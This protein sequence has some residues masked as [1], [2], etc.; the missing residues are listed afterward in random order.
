MRSRKFALADFCLRHTIST[1]YASFVLLCFILTTFVVRWETLVTRIQIYNSQDPERPVE[2]FEQQRQYLRNQTKTSYK[3]S[4]ISSNKVTEK[5]KYADV[6]LKFKEKKNIT[7]KYQAKYYQAAP[8]ER[9][10]AKIENK[11][12]PENYIL[13]KKRFV[14]SVSCAKIVRGSKRE[15]T[16]SADLGNDYLSVLSPSYYIRKTE[17]CDDFINTREYITDSLSKEE[18]EFPLAY[19]ILVY[20][21]VY[22]FERL[23]RSIYRPQNFYCIHADMKMSD[24]D[25]DAVRYIISCFD[26]VFFSSKAYN[27]AWGTFSV[28]A[29]D[30]TCMTNL[31]KYKWKYFINL[32]GQEF[33][34]KTNREIVKILKSFNG[35]ND[36]HIETKLNWEQ[37]WEKAGPVPD[38]LTPYKG[39]VH[40]AVNRNFA[41]FVIRNATSLRLMNWL[42]R[43]D[44]PDEIFFTTLNHNPHLG[45][46]GSYAGDLKKKNNLKKGDVAR[47]KKWYSTGCTGQEQHGICIASVKDLQVLARRPEMF[48]NKLIWDNDHYTFDCLEELIYNR[49][50]DGYNENTQFDTTE[51]SNLFFV[52]NALRHAK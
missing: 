8:W 26:N 38:K 10:H 47:Y 45:I 23:L 44:I 29:A 4:K 25:Y 41:E 43:T 15:I 14:K 17:N 6:H 1:K 51:Y 40:V 13:S 36:V 37:R 52:R 7:E 34:L 42:K 3:I 16:K 11:D 19:S 12:E 46:P 31:L 9:I 50:V 33:P 21:S 20:K 5:N 2:I 30:L 22:Q 27:V 39:S 24:V 32:T 28:L 18:K 49:T 48:V 35:A